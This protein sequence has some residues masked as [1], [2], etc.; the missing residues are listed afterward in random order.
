M[1][2]IEFVSYGDASGYGQ[3]AVGYVR[4]LLGAGFTVHWMPFLNDALWTG[5]FGSAQAGAELARG[6]A[7]LRLRGQAGQQNDLACLVDAT[8]RPVSADLRILH[9]IPHYWTAFRNQAPNV[10]HIGITAW[11]SDSIATAWLPMLASVDHLIV[12]STHNAQVLAA[13]RSSGAALPPASVVPHL[14]RPILQPPPKPRLEALAQW[15][16]IRPDDTVFYSINAWDPYPRK[17]IAALIDG[18]ARTFRAEDPAVLVVKTSRAAQRDHPAGSPGQRDV[19]AIVSTILTRAA[20][21]TGRPGGRIA[22]LAQD[23]MADSLID[24]LHTLGQCFVTLSRC[25]GFGLGAFDAATHG[26]PVIAVG[27]GGSVDYLGADWPGRIPHRMVPCEAMPGYHWFDAGQSWPEPDDAAAFNL[28]RDVMQAPRPFLAAADGVRDRI[29]RVFGTG[30]ITAQL[31]EAIG[32]V[33]PHLGR[34]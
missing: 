25:E 20:A 15:A 8:E 16:G 4:L 2:A 19:A 27:Y 31:R 18:F 10:P 5:R 21:E 23:D 34:R 14:S 24:G 3:A 17:R 1:P 28:M 9:V 22:L 30:T 32:S 29:G 6:R 7:A 11:E 13:A 33:V 26:R 12:P